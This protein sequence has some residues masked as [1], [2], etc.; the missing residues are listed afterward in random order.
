[1]ND[2]ERYQLAQ[3]IV[4]IVPLVMRSVAADLRQVTHFVDQSHFH[5]LWVLEHSACTL[6][7]LAEKRSVS[8]PTI[9]NSI[10]TLEERGWVQRTRSTAD[11]RKVVI[12]ITDAGRD[13]LN[14][15]RHHTVKRVEEVIAEISPAEQE[16]IS[17]G[18]LILRDAFLKAA[19]FDHCAPEH[20]KEGER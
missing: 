1:M 18:L 5:L 9:S 10:T 3:Q 12:E 14:H 19:P 11:R 17:V 2:E 20:L 6:S 7:E 15:V 4:E 13:I 16:K 8:L